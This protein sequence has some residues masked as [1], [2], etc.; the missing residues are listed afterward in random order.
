MMNVG[1]LWLDDA[2]NRSIAEKVE[3]AAAYYQQKYGKVPDYCLVSEES[4]TEVLT[5]GQVQVHPAKNIRPEHF[6]IGINQG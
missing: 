4:I 2:K 5:I 1:M 3:R 6:W